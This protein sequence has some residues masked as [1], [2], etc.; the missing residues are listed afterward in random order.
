MWTQFANEPRLCT[1]CS[2]R[3]HFPLR[4]SASS[5]S[6]TNSVSPTHFLCPCTN[7]FS[8]SVFTP[9][10]PLFFFSFHKNLAMLKLNFCILYFI[11]LKKYQFCTSTM[12]VKV[13]CFFLKYCFCIFLSYHSGLIK[14]LALNRADIFR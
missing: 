1:G 11:Q 3:I 4:L 6:F 10:S 5:P 12:Q 7:D 9:L 14:V 2:I 8:L 13:F